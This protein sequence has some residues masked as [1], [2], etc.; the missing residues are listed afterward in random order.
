MTSD[1]LIIENPGTFSDAA[2][3][4]HI[5]GPFSGLEVKP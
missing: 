5:A 1:Q 4:A 3:G 2:R